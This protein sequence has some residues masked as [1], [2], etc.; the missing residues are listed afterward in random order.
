VRKI[1]WNCREQRVIVE[2]W[3]M[4]AREKSTIEPSIA[5]WASPRRAAVVPHA[6]QPISIDGPS[7]LLWLQGTDWLFFERHGDFPVPT[8]DTTW[9]R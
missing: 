3:A 6:A 7:L 2:D 4:D 9:A 1:F 5:L 8:N